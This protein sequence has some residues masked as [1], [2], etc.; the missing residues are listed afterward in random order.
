[1]NEELQKKDEYINKQVKSEIS[2]IINPKIKEIHS[3]IIDLEY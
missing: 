1:M 3:Y 2:S